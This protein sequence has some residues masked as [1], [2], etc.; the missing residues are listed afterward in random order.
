MDHILT[1][2]RGRMFSIQGGSQPW[3]HINISHYDPL[4]NSTTQVST[5]QLNQNFLGKTQV[6]VFFKSSPADSKVQS[7]LRTTKN[8]CLKLTGFLIAPIV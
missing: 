8:S 6:P 4:T 2:P 5:Q 3:L 1:L 7:K